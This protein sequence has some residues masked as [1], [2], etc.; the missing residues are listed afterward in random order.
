MIEN[1]IKLVNVVQVMLVRWVLP[2]QR[3]SCNLWEF[4]L[5]KHQ[6]LLGLFGMTHEEIWKVLFKAGRRHRLRPM[7]AG[8]A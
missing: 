6:T 7:T 2:C 5:S 1:K 4:E 3:Q 8:L